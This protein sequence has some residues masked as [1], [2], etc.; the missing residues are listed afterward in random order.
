MKNILVVL[1]N[2]DT[3]TFSGAVAS[4]Y[5]EAASE[6]GFAVDRINIG[7]LQFDPVLHRGY[8]EE[9]HLEESL[10]M[11]QAKIE[12]ADHIVVVYPNWWCS[13]PALLKGLFDRIWLHGFAFTFNEKKGRQE[14]LL[15]GKTGRVII[16]TGM[17]SPLKTWWKFGDYTN[18]IT[19]G[20]LGFAGIMTR[21]TAL[22]PVDNSHGAQRAKWINHISK[23][24]SK[25]L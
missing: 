21:V 22:G 24:A 14:P 3:D 11:V 25:G 1:G 12:W 8:K 15:T 17:Y 13:M 19:H 2:P 10:T 23:L 20:I 5:F 4:C 7:E 6:A 18:E 9:Q 16:V